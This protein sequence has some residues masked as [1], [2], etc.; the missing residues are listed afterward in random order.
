MC[1]RLGSQNVTINLVFTVFPLKA[2]CCKIFKL[3]MQGFFHGV[4]SARR[5]LVENNFFKKKGKKKKER[6]NHRGV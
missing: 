4:P 5:G 3:S 2:E 6:K 1:M